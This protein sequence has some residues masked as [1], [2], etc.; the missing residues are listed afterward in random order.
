MSDIS[1]IYVL[2]MKNLTFRFLAGTFF[3]SWTLWGIV[4]VLGMEYGNLLAIALTVSGVVGPSVG[5]YVSTPSHLRAFNWRN[6]LFILM[7]LVAAFLLRTM[8]PSTINN[9]LAME[10]LIQNKWGLVI[11]T[12]MILMLGFILSMLKSFTT[13]G[14]GLKSF[15]VALL[16]FPAIIGIVNIIMLFLPIPASFMVSDLNDQSWIQIAIAGIFS[17]PYYF[18]LAGGIEETGWRGVLLP[19]LQKKFSPLLSSIMVSV[20][21]AL[22][23]IPLHWI[24]TDSTPSAWGFMVR[25]GVSLI[26][27]VIFTCFYNRYRSVVLLIVL[28]GMSNF[29]LSF[30]PTHGLIWFSVLF[31]IAIYMV[32]KERMWIKSS[33]WQ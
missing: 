13:R 3:F 12:F 31:L 11:F 8:R 16:F 25:L 10:Q 20:V 7:I 24:K 1:I 21:W 19:E 26:L 30:F 17:L 9:D 32:I 14:I 4:L 23:H 6:F 15:L 27:S 18:L 2:K 5:A 33:N 29:C 22:W 28:H